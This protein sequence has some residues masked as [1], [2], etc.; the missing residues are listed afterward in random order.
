[1]SLLPDTLISRQ[2]MASWLAETTMLSRIA[3]RLVQPGDQVRLVEV[4]APL[5]Y[6]AAEEAEPNHVEFTE[7]VI[8]VRRRY[9]LLSPE[10]LEDVRRSL[11]SRGLT[12]IDELQCLGVEEVSRS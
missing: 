8:T 3:G 6:V 12:W 11:E 9:E 1:M 2:L 7:R 10:D 4:Q 5:M